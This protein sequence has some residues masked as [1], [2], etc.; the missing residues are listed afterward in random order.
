MLLASY[1]RVCSTRWTQISRLSL[2]WLLS[3][4]F[5]LFLSLHL[6]RFPACIHV[7]WPE[8]SKH[9]FTHSELLRLIQELKQ[10]EALQPGM[11][12]HARLQK[13]RDMSCI[14][15][16]WPGLPIMPVIHQNM[17]SLK[18]RCPTLLA[19]THYQCR[20]IAGL[21][22]GPYKTWYGTWSPDN[23]PILPEISETKNQ[24]LALV[25]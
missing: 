23:A 24:C 12:H 6:L 2:L 4:H 11:G 17:A 16:M 18:S 13:K 21:S 7:C 1:E 5:A 3:M 8:G 10:Q 20:T 25:R 15:S 9:S 19:S 22:V 14:I